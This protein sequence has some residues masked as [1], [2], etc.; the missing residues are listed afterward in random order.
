MMV[1]MDC[2][3]VKNFAINISTSILVGIGLLDFLALP[4]DEYALYNNIPKSNK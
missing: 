2:F 3:E 4:D 1:N